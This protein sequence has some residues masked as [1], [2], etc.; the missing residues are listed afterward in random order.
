MSARTTL[1]CDNCGDE[2]AGDGFPPGWRRFSIH[3]LISGVAR[4]CDL[5]LN[6]TASVRLI[7]LT[8]KMEMLR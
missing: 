7:E 4:Q 1:I 6:C 2:H 3:D 5:C 8:T